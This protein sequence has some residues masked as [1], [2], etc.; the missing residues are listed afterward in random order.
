MFDLRLVE[1]AAFF[2]SF[3]EINMQNDQ[4]KKKEKVIEKMFVFMMNK[5]F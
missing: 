3:D 2:F 4:K 5:I 1:F